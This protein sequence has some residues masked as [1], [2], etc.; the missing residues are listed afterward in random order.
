MRQDLEN[1]AFIAAGGHNGRRAGVNMSCLFDH[2]QGHFHDEGRDGHQAGPAIDRQ[3]L[4]E[5]GLPSQEHIA[6]E[7]QQSSHDKDDR[8][9]NDQRPDNIADQLHHRFRLLLLHPVDDL[10]FLL[11]GQPGVLIDLIPRFLHSKRGH[12]HTADHHDDDQHDHGKE[13]GRRAV[14]GCEGL[15]GFEEYTPGFLHDAH[16]R[17]LFGLYRLWFSCLHI[18]HRN[19]PFFICYRRQ[20]LFV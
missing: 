13:P 12:N 15:A 5:V 3:D 18:F 10:F 6:T 16:P 7:I 17:R 1:K 14:Q 2:H 20:A 19:S 8:E 4:L 9:D 11:G